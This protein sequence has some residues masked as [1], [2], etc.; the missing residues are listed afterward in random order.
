KFQVITLTS[1]AH[2]STCFKPR[3]KTLEQRV[4]TD[5]CYRPLEAKVDLSFVSDVVKHC[6]ANALGS[7]SSASAW[8]SAGS[9]SIQPLTPE[10]GR[11]DSTQ[12]LAR[13]AATLQRRI[14]RR[15][16][17]EVRPIADSLATCTDAR[18]VLV[19]QPFAA[20]PDH[21]AHGLSTV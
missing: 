19:V 13:G 12:P 8:R 6:W 1:I 21:D 3:L 11:A 10:D 17:R 15:R 9:F 7:P 5:N 16:L 20:G 14:G 18:A 2:K 4:P